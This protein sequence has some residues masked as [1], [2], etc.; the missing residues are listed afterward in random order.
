M[1]SRRESTSGKEQG[2]LKFS[3]TEASPWSNQAVGLPP[4]GLL[5]PG[6]S[7]FLR[8]ARA[9]LQ[10]PPEVHQASKSSFPPSFHLSLNLICHYFTYSSHSHGLSIS[11]QC[12]EESNGTGGLFTLDCKGLQARGPRAGIPALVAQG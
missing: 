6:L 12:S 4:P 3:R 11:I 5:L 8:Q 7:G 2:L 10:K 9:C 1:G